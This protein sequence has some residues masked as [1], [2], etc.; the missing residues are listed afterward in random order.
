MS[1]NKIVDFLSH[2]I[3]IFVGDFG[4]NKLKVACDPQPKN[5]ANQYASNCRIIDHYI[6]QVTQSRW[7]DE[8]NKMT[9][10]NRDAEYSFVEYEGN[11]YIIGIRL[12]SPGLTD[13]RKTGDQKL[14]KD[15]MY[16]LLASSLMRMYDG[17]PPK[18][19]AFAFG[20]PPMSSSYSDTVSDNL[21][22]TLKFKTP[23]TKTI[24]VNVV[25]TYGFTE[26]M[27]SVN[28]VALRIDGS[29][30]RLASHPIKKNNNTIVIDLGGGS[31]DIV[32]LGPGGHP[33]G[34][35]N[36]RFIGINSAIE[37]F[38][39][40]S[41][42]K[43]KKQLEAAWSKSGFSEEQI[44]QCFRSDDKSIAIGPHFYDASDIFEIA[45]N[46]LIMSMNMAFDQML[47][48]DGLSAY[49]YAMVTGGGGDILYS[50][51][52]EKLLLFFA[53]VT[54][55]GE[56]IYSNN[57]FLAGEPNSVILSNA[58]GTLDTFLLVKAG[59][60]KNKI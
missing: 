5:R 44:I 24:R 42:S 39:D 33:N 50:T 57:V 37:S 34:L 18:R 12:N 11:Y 52:C 49:T 41:R 21:I 35:T 22:G 6:Y 17:L 29:G 43:F 3:P 7:I 20:H 1:I 48:N 38:A 55:N 58:L 60:K 4:N 19:I 31:F 13:S 10:H 23:T 8:Y 51:I 53:T 30:S 32:G 56:R 9:Q 47:G 15:Y 2:D 25:S 59:I 28:R 54:V 26:I 46:D 16:P 36:T 40:L 27:G 14:T 45:I